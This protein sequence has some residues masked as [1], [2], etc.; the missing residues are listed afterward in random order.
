MSLN[1]W[2]D[3]LH[4][5][6]FHLRWIPHQLTEQLRGRRVQKCEELLL[7]LDSMAVNKFRTSVIRDKSWFVFECQHS[8]K[9]GVHREEAP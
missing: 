9:L 3:W 6:Y 8:A 7:L 4:L 5:K 1:H 2:P